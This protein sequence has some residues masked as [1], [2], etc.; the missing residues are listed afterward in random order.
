MPSPRGTNYANLF[1]PKRSP[2]AA[3]DAAPPSSN[4]NLIEALQKFAAA[5]LTPEQ[6][7]RLNNLVESSGGPRATVAQDDPVPFQGA[8]KTGVRKY[9]PEAVENAMDFLRS[10]GIAE[11]DIDWIRASHN[12]EKP[13]QAQDSARREQK[14]KRDEMN[15]HT[16]FPETRRLGGDGGL[17]FDRGTDAAQRRRE[18]DNNVRNGKSYAERFPDAARII[19]SPY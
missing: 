9:D 8:P 6:A 14:R 4:G 17:A 3:Y 19:V 11:N 1:L 15:Y 13:T 7:A 16:R 5:E 12:V 18:A 2:V 10:K